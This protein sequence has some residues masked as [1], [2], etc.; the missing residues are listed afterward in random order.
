MRGVIDLWMVIDTPDKL[1]KT[2]EVPFDLPQIWNILS[3]RNDINDVLER[4]T[5]PR[6]MC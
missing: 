2:E 1:K 6:C 5:S 4:A 3:V